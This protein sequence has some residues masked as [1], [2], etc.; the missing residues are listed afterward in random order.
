MKHSGTY[1]YIY[2]IRM[3]LKMWIFWVMSVPHETQHRSVKFCQCKQSQ[4]LSTCTYLSV[5]IVYT[6][7][8]TCI[9]GG[10][11]SVVGPSMPL[12]Y[13]SP[14]INTHLKDLESSEQ[15]ESGAVQGEQTQLVSV[16]YRQT[17]RQPVRQTCQKWQN[18]IDIRIIMCITHI[19]NY[20]K[21][22]FYSVAIFLW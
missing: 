18:L 10:E 19:I 3:Y 4:G 1:I 6:C 16:R 8:C 14:P 7:T 22:Y 11:Q 15:S 12:P 21:S 9:H 2:Y 17:P 5:Y 20:T 13:P